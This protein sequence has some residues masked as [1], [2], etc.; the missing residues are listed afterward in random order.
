LLEDDYFG[1]EALY[2]LLVWWAGFTGN[3]KRHE[4]TPI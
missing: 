4:I 3:P 1:L 2:F